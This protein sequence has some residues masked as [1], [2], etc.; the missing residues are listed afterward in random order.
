MAHGHGEQTNVEYYA[1][2][3]AHELPVVD[4]NRS[5]LKA[6]FTPAQAQ[7]YRAVS[8]RVD[9]ICTVLYTIAFPIGASVLTTRTDLAR[10]LAVFKF[11]FQVPTLLLASADLRLDLLRI[12]VTTYEFCFFTLLNAAT[13][14][15]LSMH[16]GD[17]R[18][19]LA[20]VYWYGV[21]MN[22]WADAKLTPDVHPVELVS[23]SN[24]TMS[25][26][27]FLLNAFTTMT[28]LMA[29][30]AYRKR[31]LSNG[32][33]DDPR[34]L[35]FR[36]LV[37]RLLSTFDFQF[38]SLQITLGH[39]CLCVIATWDI[40]CYSV[41]ASW[42]WL[43]W[44]L[45]L[46]AL[47][48]AARSVL[49]FQNHLTILVLLLIATMQILTSEHILSSGS[50]NVHGLVFLRADIFGR[51]VVAKAVPFYLSRGFT[52]LLW[53]ARIMWRLLR[54]DPDELTMIQGSVEFYG[55]PKA[56][57]TKAKSTIGKLHKRISGVLLREKS[58]VQPEHT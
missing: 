46:D 42:L 10:V 12:L 28:V 49:R 35:R 51:Q 25:S 3:E 6:L 4:V 1:L 50:Q 55:N 11:V 15:I 44:A 47:T 16:L 36:Q 57:R 58:R 41:L 27:D 29:R 17:Q 38:L 37:L 31:V 14:V 34:V 21:Q 13:C 53:M 5:L 22:V 20:P 30:T 54:S 56:L 40:R 43:H 32:S 52:T 33:D 48:P 45:T 19:I 24:H 26:T 7:I 39:I 2:V 9:P 18:M 23:T 8:K